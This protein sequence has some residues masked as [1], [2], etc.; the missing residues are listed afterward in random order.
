MYFAVHHQTFKLSEEAFTEPIESLVVNRNNVFCA[1][2]VRHGDCLL[3]STVVQ[4]PGLIGSNRHD[5]CIEWSARAKVGKQFRVRSI[6]AK[7]NG[8]SFATE[9][10][11]IVAALDFA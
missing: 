9:H 7:Q 3:G 4:N 8:L 11:A 1:R 10:V 6:S 5:G 2:R